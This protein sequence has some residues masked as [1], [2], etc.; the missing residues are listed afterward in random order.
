[1]RLSKRILIASWLVA[2]AF[3]WGQ[4]TQDNERSPVP[5][6]R[7]FMSSIMVLGFS[8]SEQQIC[9]S[10]DRTGHY[11]MLREIR[12]VITE[13]TQ[14]SPV[15]NKAVSFPP[16]T[17]LFQ[18]IM[19]ASELEKFEKL[20]ANSEFVKITASAPKWNSLQKGAEDFVAEVPSRKRS[21]TRR[22]EKFR[23]GRPVPAFGSRN[24]QLASTIQD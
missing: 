1:M 22:H 23:R 6:L 7:K 3:A 20:I 18:G 15:Y 12:R 4:N 8:G 2:S 17:E 13:R 14:G 16:H 10:V 5:V 11:Q 19:L 24:H 21:T 9:F